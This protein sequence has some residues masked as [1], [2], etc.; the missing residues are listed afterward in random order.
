MKLRNGWKA[1][2]CSLV[3]SSTLLLAGPVLADVAAQGADKDA[4]P[5]KKLSRKELNK[6]NGVKCKRVRETGSR[7]SKKVCT[8]AAQRAA[9]ARN[10]RDKVHALENRAILDAPEGV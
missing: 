7:V 4:K 8:T 3:V 10:E 6:L 2:V 9:S 5:A 1:A